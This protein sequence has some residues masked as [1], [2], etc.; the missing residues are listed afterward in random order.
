MNDPDY[1]EE[2]ANLADPDQLWRLSGIEQLNLPKDKVI[3]LRTGVF[4]RRHASDLR[5]LQRAL[6][7]DK[8]VLYTPLSNSGKSVKFIETPE[9]VKVL[10]TAVKRD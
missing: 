6:K 2:L 8:S 1:V 4:L 10:K 7:E 3:Q 5:N 9:E